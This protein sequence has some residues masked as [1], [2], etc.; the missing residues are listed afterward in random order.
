MSKAFGNQFVRWKKTLFAKCSE[1]SRCQGKLVVGKPFD[2]VAD[3]RD[4]YCCALWYRAWSP[5][6]GDICDQAREFPQRNR[7]RI[8]HVVNLAPQTVFGEHKLDGR[9][10]ILS[11][12]HRFSHAPVADKAWLPT[13]YLPHEGRQVRFVPSAVDGRRS[14]DGRCASR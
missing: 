1:A 14:Q 3:S 4:G 8:R 13:Q 9:R 11:T 7:L 6:P 10:K 5:G 12:H 2:N